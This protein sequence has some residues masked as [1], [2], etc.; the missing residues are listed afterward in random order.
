MLN[1]IHTVQTDLRYS[2]RIEGYGFPTS[3]CCPVSSLNGFPFI[4]ICLAWNFNFSLFDLTNLTSVSARQVTDCANRCWLLKLEL[5]PCVL[6]INICTPLCRPVCTFI[7]IKRIAHRLMIWLFASSRPGELI[8]RN[9][10]ARRWLW[11]RIWTWSRLSCTRQ[12]GFCLQLTNISKGCSNCSCVFRLFLGY[13]R[14]SNILFCTHLE[15][16]YRQAL[17]SDSTWCTTE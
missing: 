8:Q 2:Y 5:N 12:S 3:V 16:S 13:N 1:R 7:F 6:W 14:T 9:V 15:G 10:F 11:I 4:F 17:V